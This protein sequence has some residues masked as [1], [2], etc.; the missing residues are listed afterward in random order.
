MHAETIARIKHEWNEEVLRVQR[1]ERP[2]AF[3]PLPEIPA[4]RYTREDFYRLE[5]ERLW[6]RS[7]L[8]AGHIS[9]LPDE[10]SFK[11]WE[12]ANMPVILVRGKDKVIRAFFNACQHRGSAVVSEATGLR[13]SFS[14]VYHG[15]TYGLDGALNFVTDEFE[16]AG[17]D[18]TRKGLKP[19]RCELWGSLIFVNA[20]L[21]AM[22]LR[23]HLAGIYDQL[24]DMQFESLTMFAKL[25]YDIDCNWKCVQDAFAEGYHINT[26][27]KNTVALFLKPEVG[28]R[29][30]FPHG[31]GYQIVSQNTGEA[32]E[33]SKFFDRFAMD[34]D[35]GHEITRNSSRAHSIFPNLTI[36]V[37]TTQFPIIM[38][39]PK[40]PHRCTVEVY[41]MATPG[42]GDPESEACKTV[43]QMFDVV[44]Q[45]D[46]GVL[47][48]QQRGLNSG[49]ISSVPLSYL[50]RLIY[51]HHEHLDRV[52]GLDHVPPELR[53]PQIL[54][55]FIEP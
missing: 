10:G 42:H 6:P 43:T 14:C 1:R 36:P 19:L 52:L 39:W 54:G 55:P 16:F 44:T 49:A 17:L 29:R 53:V 41:Y 32:F 21:N 20:D 38:P 47:N 45:E 26:V 46:L 22:S 27:H 11:R 7:W 51:N 48:A 35:P 9:E 5:Q 2:A 50:E 4:G 25:S 31:H 18:K 8:L 33:E 24:D 23:D 34:M 13:K 30:L 28:T 37:T 40:G 12:A 3:P 15:W